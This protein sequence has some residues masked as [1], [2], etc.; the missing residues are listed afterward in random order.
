MYH[1]YQTPDTPLYSRDC[2]DR[3]K[4][5]PACKLM[6]QQSSL[7]E[8]KDLETIGKAISAIPLDNSTYYL[9]IDLQ[10]KNWRTLYRAELSNAKHAL[11]A[12]K[13]LY[14]NLHKIGQYQAFNDE[15]RKSIERNH[16]RFL[17]DHEA[18][19][20]LNGPHAFGGINYSLKSS[21][22]SQKIRPVRDIVHGLKL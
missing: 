20:V 15:I 5:C 2:K 17:D 22:L 12:S 4:C 8:L 1:E 13:R 14:K 7:L 18:Q 11:I 3:V 10:I 21:S 9:Y 16:F 19:A 6:S